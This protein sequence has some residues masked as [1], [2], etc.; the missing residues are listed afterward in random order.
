MQ[1]SHECKFHQSLC[2]NNHFKQVSRDNRRGVNPQSKKTT[3]S[4][5]LIYWGLLAIL[6]VNITKIAIFFF[7]EI[8]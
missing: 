2:K 5:M 8:F 1:H 6:N 4:G 7:F 3:L